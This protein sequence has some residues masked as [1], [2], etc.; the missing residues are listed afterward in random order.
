MS[1]R[2]LTIQDSSLSLRVVKSP[3]RAGTGVPPL[4]AVSGR[5][6]SPFRGTAALDGPS[7][8]RGGAIVSLSRRSGS[9]QP[10]RRV[11]IPPTGRPSW[12][13]A[14]L[15]DGLG[16]S[17]RR[18]D[19][20]PRR[21][22]AKAD[23]IE[24][25]TYVDLLKWDRLAWIV[26]AMEPALR[27]AR[28]SRCIEGRPRRRGTGSAASQLSAAFERTGPTQVSPSP[29]T[30]GFGSRAGRLRPAA[31][32]CEGRMRAIRHPLRRR[33]AGRTALRSSPWAD[34]RC[35]E[36][37]GGSRSTS[38]AFG[39]GVAVGGQERLRANPRRS[40]RNGA[41]AGGSPVAHRQCRGPVYGLPPCRCSCK[42]HEGRKPRLIVRRAEASTWL[43]IQEGRGARVVSADLVLVRPVRVKADA[44][45]RGIAAVLTRAEPRTAAARPG[46]A[47][48]PRT[49][50]DS[51]PQH[52]VVED[53]PVGPPQVAN[54]DPAAVQNS[55]ARGSVC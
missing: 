45:G 4:A 11:S 16:G 40:H 51:S 1:S 43:G 38:P 13:P 34:N 15:G 23:A 30:R 12:R 19:R 41:G 31:F 26:G 14:R 3:Y 35:G 9:S 49:S 53:R 47:P 46:A 5:T 8:C 25:Q 36:P 32:G 10:T 21:A 50:A 24:F 48:Y 42:C 22:R 44:A 33:C 37:G 55:R 7:R 29:S 6:P 52:A 54:E 2:V 39:V 27:P 20:L 28:P 17:G 18:P